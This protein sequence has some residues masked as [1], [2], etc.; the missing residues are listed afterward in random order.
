MRETLTRRRWLVGTSAIAACAWLG[1]ARATVMEAMSLAD[2]ARAS[3]RVVLARVGSA[4][5]SWVSG[6]IVTDVDVQIETALRGPAAPTT[7]RVRLPGGIV[8]DVGQQLAGAP[9]LRAGERYVLFLRNGD[10]GVY[11]T[12][13]L[14]QGVLPVRSARVWPA[15]VTGLLVAGR[16]GPLV[17]AGGLSLTD[18][19]SAL[20]AR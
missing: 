4:R 14:S 17:P 1:R 20:A 6:R 16:A 10:P 12:V 15:D 13:G 3:D 8:G 2:L 11:F 7:I 19:V 18:F 5:A 9:E